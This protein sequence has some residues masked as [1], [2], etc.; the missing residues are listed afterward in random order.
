[1]RAWVGALD[2]AVARAKRVFDPGLMHGILD[3]GEFAMIDHSGIRGI[4]DPRRRI[5]ASDVIADLAKIA[6]AQEL[7]GWRGEQP[8][9]VAQ[10]VGDVGRSTGV[11]DRVCS[12][13]IGRE[14]HIDQESVTA[15]QGA[16]VVEGR[17]NGRLDRFHRQAQVVG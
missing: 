3:V 13:G 9:V 7:S 5:R 4:S 6:R 15:E 1:M 8:H 12:R 14:L 17:V 11:Q 2:E 16:A 10:R